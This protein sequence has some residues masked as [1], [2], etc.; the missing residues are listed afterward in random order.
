MKKNHVVLLLVPA[1]TVFTTGDTDCDGKATHDAINSLYPAPEGG[2]AGVRAIYVKTDVSQAV[3]V[4]DLVKACV[5]TFGRLDMYVRFCPGSGI[6]AEPSCIVNSLTPPF[7]A[8]PCRMV[9]NAGVGLELK[10]IHD[11]DESNWDTVMGI[12]G[13]GTW[14]GCS[15]FRISARAFARGLKLGTPEYAIGQMLAQEPNP[16]GDRGWVINMNSVHGIVGSTGGITPYAASK[17]AIVMMTKT[18]ALEYGNDRM[19]V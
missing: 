11:L 6:V 2:R 5:R 16:S 12:N 18:L 7:G 9:N 10:R 4:E 13:K 3:E 17:G 1:D 14:L 8:N 15:K 19:L